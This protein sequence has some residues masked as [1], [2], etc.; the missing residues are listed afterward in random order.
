MLPTL[1]HLPT[2]WVSDSSQS[3]S[4]LGSLLNGLV[5]KPLTHPPYPTYIFFHLIQYSN[6]VSRDRLFQILFPY[7]SASPI[8]H[9]HILPTLSSRLEYLQKAVTDH[10]C[11]IS[12]LSSPKFS[13]PSHLSHLLG[14]ASVNMS[15]FRS[16]NFNIIPM[17][18]SPPADLGSYSRIM[19]RHTQ[20]QMEAISSSSHSPERA[21]RSSG[22]SGPTPTMNG[23]STGR[24][25]SR[26]PS[27]YS[28]TT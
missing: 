28:Y 22:N 16:G 8:R 23:T 15:T 20:Q 14:E 13:R 10:F 27:E 2:P 1:T 24:R 11:P 12:L 18:G 4:R 19:H 21:S 9:Y 5:I 26:S 17:S 3:P 7:G 6:T 25:S